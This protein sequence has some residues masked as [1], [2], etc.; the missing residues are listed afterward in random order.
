[1]AY[2]L[3]TEGR[4]DDAFRAFYGAA[5]AGS[6]YAQM[7]LGW[8]YACGKGVDPNLEEAEKW[9]Q[10]AAMSDSAWAQCY[11]AELYR[12]IG[13]DAEARYW[14]EK[15]AAKGH[16]PARRSIALDMIKGRRG[17]RRIPAG[18]L[19]FLRVLMSG[20]RQ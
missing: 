4:Y 9:Y 20:R 17:I 11:L 19:L 12:M 7:M 10:K 3:L 5:Q 2:N 16:V 1:M 13:R 18:V 8:M 14:L 15:A 6:A